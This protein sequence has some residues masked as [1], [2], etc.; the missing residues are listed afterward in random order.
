[1]VVTRFGV[2]VGLLLDV[3]ARHGVAAIAS[4]DL[5]LLSH[6]SKGD[7]SLVPMAHDVAATILAR[8]GPVAPREPVAADE[9]ARLPCA[10]PEG[11]L[12]V[13]PPWRSRP[14][15]PA[16]ALGRPDHR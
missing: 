7:A 1:V 5:G 13:R 2:D 3:A 12:V 10:G 16:V 9:A 15:T 4:V 14:A 6:H 8:R 11:P